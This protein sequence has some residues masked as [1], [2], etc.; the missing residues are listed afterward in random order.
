MTS[1]ATAR[2]FINI[3]APATLANIVNYHLVKGRIVST[4]LADGQVV[5]TQLTGKTF[6]VNRSTSFTLTDG[7]N[8]VSTVTSA[9]NLTN[10]GVLHQINKV[11]EF[12]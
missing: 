7:K 11:L 10:A 12:N 5:T 8:G 9:D 4:D 1:E 3:I 6:K 2:D